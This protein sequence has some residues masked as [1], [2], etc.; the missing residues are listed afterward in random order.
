MLALL[1]PVFWTLAVVVW[2]LLPIIAYHLVG[3]TALPW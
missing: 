3:A 1:R 2:V